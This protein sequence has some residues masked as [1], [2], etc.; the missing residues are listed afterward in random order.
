[1]LIALVPVSLMG[2]RVGADPSGAEWPRRIDVFMDGRV[3]IVGESVVNEQA[4]RAAIELQRYA[5]DGIQAI[6]AA[7]SNNLPTDPD[8]SRRIAL[9]R[10]QRLDD[11]AGVRMK[12]TAVGLAKAVQYGVDRYP[13]VVFDGQSVVYGVN[14][15]T[16]ALNHYRKWQA[17]RQ[18]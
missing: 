7:L 2:Q 8:R 10:L 6:E 1:M 5:V 3:P 11:A 18:P 17:G 13:A 9:Q 14:D 15:L 16:V 4:G 12:G